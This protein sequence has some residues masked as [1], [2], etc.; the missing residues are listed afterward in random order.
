MKFQIVGHGVSSKA[1]KRLLNKHHHQIVSDHPDI[2]VLSPGYPVDCKEALYA[3]QNGAEII[4]EAELAFRYMQNRAVG[5]TG[6]NGKTTTVLLI[7]HVLN[8][9]GIKAKALGNIGHAL[10]DYMCEPDPK[11]IAVVELSSFQLETLK[12]PIFCASGITNISPDH[13]DRYASFSEYKAMKERIFHFTKGPC[14]TKDVAL[15]L[16]RHLGISNEQYETAL[17]TFK[18]PPHRLELIKKVDGLSFYNDSKGTNVDAV[19]YAVQNVPGPIFLIAGGVDKK[20][21]YAIWNR[22]FKQKVKA[23]LTI[24]EASKKIKDEVDQLNVEC[25]ETLD[26]ALLRAV[27]LSK[28][29]G[30]ILLSPGCSSFDQ[31]NDYIHRGEEFERLV[32]LMYES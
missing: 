25:V 7:E 3:R 26:K 18:R 24:G 21:S 22:S 11:E 17:Q 23:I 15:N 29:K 28:G 32:R 31:F 4:G 5:V 19:C 13:L 12:T 20:G 14:Y 27:S 30:T 16:C 2:L 8:T 10:C 1:V 6:T 9:F